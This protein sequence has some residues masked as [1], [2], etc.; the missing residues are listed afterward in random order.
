M[1]GADKERF[2]TDTSNGMRMRR[3]RGDG[4]PGFVLVK[5]DVNVRQSVVVVL[6]QM[7]VS[8][9]PQ[10]SPQRTRA[11]TDNH[12]CDAKLQPTTDL[13]RD[14][15]SQREHDNTGNQKCHCMTRAPQRP[16]QYRAKQV[17][18]LTHNCRHGHHVIDFSRVLKT[19]DQSQAEQG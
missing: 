15:N 7:N 11:Q 5:M 3:G 13:L 6:M 2:N 19:K 17:A 4:M 9:L 12:E 18:M 8:R 16:Y 1:H 10:R 14:C